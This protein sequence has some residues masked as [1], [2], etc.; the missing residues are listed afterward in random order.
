MKKWLLRIVGIVIFILILRS[1][2]L[3]KTFGLFFEGNWVVILLSLL[4]IFPNIGFKVLRWKAYMKEQ[5]IKYGFV[6]AFLA[7]FSGFFVGSVTPGRV[8]DLVK[9][10]YL[11]DEGYPTGKGLVSV[12]LD[13][14]LDMVFLVGAAYIFMYSFFDLLFNIILWLTVAIVIGLIVLLF[15]IYKEKSML[16]ILRVGYR[17][18][19]PKKYKAKAKYTFKEFYYGV[20]SVRLR[21]HFTG[22]FYTFLAWLMYWIQIF[23]IS[24]ALGMDI[25]FFYLVITITLSSFVSLLPVT[26]SGVGTRDLVFIYLFGLVGVGKEA[27]IALSFGVLLTFVFNAIVGWIAWMIKPISFKEV[28]AY[29]KR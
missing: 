27:A 6:E 24:K 20:K 3:S 15:F 9:V 12:L 1:V 14:F 23:V 29:A 5:G 26:V 21:V 8:G 4:L 17:W 25:E 19:I 18:L 13:R 2:D 22:L 10:L 7:Y 16:N 11:R 28:K